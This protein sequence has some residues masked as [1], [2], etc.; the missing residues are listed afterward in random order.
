MKQFLTTALLISATFVVGAR[1]AKADACSDISVLDAKVNL[2]KAIGDQTSIAQANAVAA[3]ARADMVNVCE[4]LFAG[5]S[6]SEGPLKGYFTG[7]EGDQR[8]SKFVD[9][10]MN[11][12]RANPSMGNKAALYSVIEDLL[13][14]S[15]K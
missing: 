7:P 11:K 4:P 12:C 15:S 5:L 14:A 8:K 13:Q 9:S 10:F 1:Q 3:A 2:V 6:T